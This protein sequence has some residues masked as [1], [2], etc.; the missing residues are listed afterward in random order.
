MASPNKPLLLAELGIPGRSKDP[1]STD[2]DIWGINIAAALG[3]FPLHGLQCQ[4]GPWGNMASGDRLTIFWGTGL[5]AGGKTVLKDEVGTQLR[6][7][8]PS[9]HMV[10]GQ[11]AVSYV[12][13]P[14]GGTDQ[15]SEVMQVLV[16]LTRPGGHDE[17]GDGGHSKLIMII[18][19]D[20]LDGGIDKEIAEKGVKIS[21]GKAD[22]TP[23]Y[24]Y[25]A[26]GD[27]CRV[28]WGGI[29]VLSEPL[30]QEQ[31]EGKTPIIVKIEKDFIT[32]AGDAEFPGVAVV[33][34]VYDKVFNRSEDWSPE[35]R[36]V[37]AVDATRLIAPLLKET[38]NNVLDVDQLG[39]A[40]GTVQIIAT[41]TTNFKIGDIPFIKIKG[42][43]V[44]GAPIDLEVEGA[45]LTSV[46]S[47]IEI[48]APNAVLRQLAKSQITLSY[49]LKKADGSKDLKSKSQFI[50][51]IGEVQRLAAPI[52]LDEDSGALDPTLA[53]VRLEIPFDKSFAEGQVLKIFMLGTTPGLK[54]YLPDLPLRL[55]TRN[56]IV[57]AKPLLYNIDGKHLAP[58][59]GGTAEFYYQQLIADAVLATLNPFEATRAIRESI[60]TDILQVGEP[61]LELPEPVVAGVVDGVVDGV[62]PA[63]T[64]GTTLT[65]PYTETVKG[66]EVF[67]FWIGSITGEYPDS[68]KLNEFT[69]GKE[70]P[71]NIP[72]EVI[73]GNEGGTVIARYEIKRAAGGTSY[74][75]P[76]EFSVGVAL[77]NPLPLPQM[78]EATGN[79]AS[80][81]LAPL[82]AQAGARVVVAYT[83]MNEKHNIKLT[84]AGTPGVGSPDIPAKQ[85]VAS[86]SVEFLIPATAIAANIGNETK[87]F[88]LSYEVTAGQTTPSLPLTVSVTPLPATE[89]DKISIEQ[90]DG[91]VLDLTKVTL[92]ATIL[93]GVWAFI[94]ANHRVGLNLKGTKNNGDAF[95]HV[96][97]P[98]PSSYVNQ[99]WFNSGQYTH[100]LAY[101]AIKDLADGSRLELHFKAALTLSREEAEAIDA[102]VK[103]Y[104]I[105]AIEDVT[106]SITLVTGSPSG[107]EVIEGAII[108]ETAVTLTGSAAKGQKVSV[109]D[110]TTSKGEP[111]ADSATGIWT[112]AVTGLS[113]APHSFT[114]RA[115]YGS[116]ASSAART[117]IVTAVVVPTLSNVW[118][119]SNVEV[120]EG[121][122][123]VSTEL[124]LKGTASL[125]QQINI[126]DGTGSGSATRGTA[127]ANGT[128]GIWELPITVPLG[129][130][131]LYAE[132][133]Y[134]SNPLYSNVRNLTVAA[135]SAPTITSVKGSPS[136]VEI[137]QGGSTVETAV[138][139]SGVAA[140]GQKVE[141]FDGTASKGQANADATIGD[142]TLLAD[143]LA[144]A[145]HSFTAK[146]LYGS[147]VVSAA[148]T[149]TV[150]PPFVIDTSTLV[151][152]GRCLSIDGTGLN[153]PRTEIDPVGTFAIRHPTSGAPP[154]T[155]RSESSATASVDS[156]G[157]VRSEWNGNTRIIVTDSLNRS[158]SFEVKVSNVFKPRVNTTGLSDRG[159]Y[160][161]RVSVGGTVINGNDLALF[162]RFDPVNGTIRLFEILTGYQPV[163]YTGP[164][165]GYWISYIQKNGPSWQY[166]APFT[167]HTSESGIEV[168]HPDKCAICF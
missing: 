133:C 97:W 29:F 135:D 61:R 13:K 108:V 47:I 73:K 48:K 72:A 23:P 12:V 17:N 52:M 5:D 146:A 43:P 60:H 130:R 126:R 129:A 96:V 33:F 149:L 1:V 123:T 115:L 157:C 168:P 105:R 55:I 93:A 156:K 120:L 53:Q 152:S 102:P 26:A 36:V 74:A 91:T 158:G 67:M 83:G 131:R 8:V 42:T 11:F 128:T 59:N 92:G 81:T 35:Q 78:P 104:T 164:G 151:L 37:V 32:D 132:A 143:G 54:P 144:V 76:L 44:E 31:A 2:P 118:D 68:I 56:D 153:W 40:D 134:P 155:F 110:G 111:T 163:P 124:T 90:A 34:E 66:D 136:D 19:Q 150:A 107:D 28:S 7:F 18:P 160:N 154:Y 101:N 103:V 137:P 65:V 114:A 87:T 16:K 119:A 109:L 30:T 15:P 117:L 122:T 62:L 69:A 64:A 63:D 38:L 121:T 80:V 116:G 6:M 45:A 138:T 85:G 99:N 112:L 88:T 139:L 51:A 4:A 167:A 94:A 71:F 50:R 89:L 162:A 161:W 46:P 147:G 75:E 98:W 20:I 27:I 148:R 58:V 10:D 142:W 49:R 145:V 166:V 113:V 165:G 82:D 9:R 106:P 141:I 84:M 100:T 79:G 22:G 159:A 41:D 57:A 25:A 127:T 125:G 77:E 70:V 21:I 140:K 24:P 3:N 39:D 86:G 14:L 95:H